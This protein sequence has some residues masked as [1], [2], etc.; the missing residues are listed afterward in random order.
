[1]AS[2][3]GTGS[4]ASLAPSAMALPP[5][6]TAKLFAIA[7]KLFKEMV[8]YLQTGLTM[9]QA[10]DKLPV[11]ELRIVAEFLGKTGAL[12]RSSS[13]HAECPDRETV[14]AIGRHHGSIRGGDLYVMPESGVVGAVVVSPETV[15]TPIQ[16]GTAVFLKGYNATA[17]LVADIFKADKRFGKSA[18]S[19]I[20]FVPTDSKKACYWYTDNASGGVTS[21]FLN[22]VLRGYKAWGA[23]DD[24]DAPPKEASLDAWAKSI[25]TGITVKLVDLKT[26][27]EED[28]R[29]ASEEAE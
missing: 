23:P 15:K 14:T 18:T 4:P 16:E 6:E 7:L 9:R 17:E 29:R 19:D 12:K 2:T 13:P 5:R 27:R 22:Q 1:M 28:L 11:E 25:E 20:V 24:Q 21:A 8:G 26:I 10:R 3:N